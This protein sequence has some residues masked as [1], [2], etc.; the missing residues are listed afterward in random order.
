MRPNAP[1]IFR[2]PQTHAN[3]SFSLVKRNTS[4]TAERGEAEN[5]GHFG[6]SSSLCVCDT[7]D[8]AVCS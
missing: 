6:E 7:P 4:H 3:A 8:F 1:F 2:G 5:L